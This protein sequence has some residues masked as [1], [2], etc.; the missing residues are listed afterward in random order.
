M[1]IVGH[2]KLIKAV[3]VCLNHYRFS[4]SYFYNSRIYRSGF[5]EVILKMEI[6]ALT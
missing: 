3:M 2:E 5:K 6:K 1:G 4:L